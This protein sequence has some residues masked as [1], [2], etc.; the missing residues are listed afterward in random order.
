MPDISTWTL[1]GQS[2]LANIHYCGALAQRHP[3]IKFVSIHPGLVKTNLGTEFMSGSNF[4]VSAALKFAMRF[5]TVDVREGAFNSLWAAINPAAESGVFYYPVGVTGKDARGKDSSG[6]E[7]S[8]PTST[9]VS[10]G[11][12]QTG[13][14]SGCQ[15]FHTVNPS[16]SNTCNN[17]WLGYAYCVKGPS[18]STTATATSSTASPSSP[19]QAGTVSNHNQYHTV[20]SGD[21]CDYIEIT[22]G[23]SFAQLYEW[24]PAIGSDCETLRVGH[25]ICVAALSINAPTQHGI[26]SDCNRWN[27]AIGSNCQT[28]GAGYSVCVGVSS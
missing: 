14:V 27:P 1:Y 23:I 10:M 19:T 22:Y 15:L 12:T 21:S 11:P 25:S 8:P 28:L 2:K 17:L 16:I 24:N 9:T 7:L 3:D 13:V 5:T 20:V 18:S 6:A 4:L 26:A